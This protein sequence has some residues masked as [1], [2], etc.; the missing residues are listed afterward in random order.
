MKREITVTGGKWGTLGFRVRRRDVSEI[1]E[2]LKDQLTAGLSI[3]LPGRTR[4]APVSV[5]RTFWTTCPS[6][7]SCEIGAWM[8]TRGDY[9]WPDQR[10]PKY[11]AEVVVETDGVTLTIRGRAPAGRGGKSGS[12]G[13]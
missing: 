13:A 3:E 10:P 12:D 2:P 8:T 11:A 6:F 7:R 4:P 5:T 9:P 1:F